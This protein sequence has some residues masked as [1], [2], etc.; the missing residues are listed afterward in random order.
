MGACMSRRK[1]TIAITNKRSFVLD[2]LLLDRLTE[3]QVQYLRVKFQE[4]Q[5]NSYLDRKGFNQIFPGLKVFPP[6]VAQKSFSIF[7]EGSSQIKFRNFC[8]IIS[9]LL[10]SSKE[11]QSKFLFSLFDTDADDLLSE[12]ELDSLLRTQALYLRKLSEIPSDNIKLHKQKFAKVPVDKV[13][14]VEWCLR[15]IELNDLLKPF[16]I[17]PSSLTEK[18]IISSKLI[19]NDRLPLD[20]FVYLI[21]SEWWTVWK[22]YV[23]FEPELEDEIEESTNEYA[24]ILPLNRRKSAHLDDR[25]VAIDN[26]QLFEYEGSCKLKLGLKYKHDYIWVKKDVWEQLFAWY[27]GGP[28]IQRKVLFEYNKPVIELY[29]MAFNIIPVD[30]QGLNLNDKKKLVVV[31]KTSLINDLLIESCKV[32]ERPLEY[33]RLLQKSKSSWIICENSK[34][35]HYLENESEILLETGY[36]EK[37]VIVWPRDHLIKQELPVSELPYLASNGAALNTTRSIYIEKQSLKVTNIAIPGVSGLANLGNTCFLNSVLQSLLHTPMLFELFLGES[38]TSFINPSKLKEKNLLALEMNLLAKEMGS[39]KISKV[40]PNK[41]HKNFIKKFPMFNGNEQ[42]DCHECLSLMLD[43]LHEELSRVGDDVIRNTLVLENPVDKQIEIKEADEQWKS[44]QGNRGSLISDV[45]GGQTR[46]SLTCENCGN[47]KVLFEIFNNLSLPIPVSMEIPLN[48]TTITFNSKPMQIALVINK[49]AKISEFIKEISK[50]INIPKEKIFLGEYYHGSTLINLTKCENEPILRF[51]RETSNLFVYE[52]INTIEEA[53][54]YGKKLVKYTNQD[55]LFKVSQHVDV[56]DSKDVWKSGKIIEAQNHNYVI[57]LDYEE[58]T[59][60]YTL[61]SLA[62][63]RTHTRC[64]LPKIINYTIYHQTQRNNN[65]EPIGFPQIISI[66]SWYTYADLYSLSHS[67]ASKLCKTQ[68]LNKDQ[69]FFKIRLLEMLNLKCG[70]WR[71][72]EGC[73][74]PKDKIELKSAENFFIG[75]EWEEK[76]FNEEIQIHPNVHEVSKINFKKP[77]DISNCFDSFMNKEKIESKCEKCGVNELCM[78]VDIWRVPDILIVSLKRFAFQHGVF[79]KIDQPVSIPFYAFDISQWVK[80]VEISGGLTL[81][82]TTLQNAY[83]LYSIILHSGSLGGG[84]YTTL[85]KIRKDDDSM[86]ALFDDMNLYMVKEDPDN[87]LVAKNAYM[88][89]Y[90]RRKFSSSNVINL[91]YNFA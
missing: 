22:N 55:N 56:M 29:P 33:S 78:Q 43:S 19:N 6:Q 25:P 7:S 74:M 83:D 37:S 38:V 53:E 69:D 39:S 67:A 41:F 4:Y 14:F 77:I 13:I 72:F 31:S 18:Q 90:R 49:F 15:N 24:S 44:L 1:S 70:T 30:S 88:L 61:P 54:A 9:K 26:K 73:P 28:V 34:S 58:K 21:S 64:E 35:V 10:L 12:N 59:G 11:E 81:S 45:C 32:F 75:V 86:W 63:F 71:S 16:E 20:E 52:T 48:V 62:P 36:I 46:T 82:T 17:I 65:P 89:F 84:H 27:G 80:G 76:Y 51:I 23:R 85:V 66:G 2:N 47:R 57:D 8:L 91:T 40:S 60:V 3:H 68:A 79:D 50:I 87:L 5:S 42:H